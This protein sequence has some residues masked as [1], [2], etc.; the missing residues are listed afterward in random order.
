MTMC[1]CQTKETLIRQL[2]LGYPRER[3]GKQ[4]APLQGLPLYPSTKQQ[5]E[6]EV[7]CPAELRSLCLKETRVGCEFSR[8]DK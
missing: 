5:M 8:S 1:A 2:I 7:L 6:T 3:W 4:A